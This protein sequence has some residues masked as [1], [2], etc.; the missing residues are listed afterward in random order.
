VHRKEKGT[1]G[2]HDFLALATSEVCVDV[3]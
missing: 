2:D 1:T 3:A